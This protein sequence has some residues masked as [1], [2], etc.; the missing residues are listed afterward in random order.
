MLLHKMF[1]I[2]RMLERNLIYTSCHFK[3]IIYNKSKDSNIVTIIIIIIIIKLIKYFLALFI[4]QHYF[5]SIFGLRN[6]YWDV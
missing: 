5:M 1:M 4:I 2:I 3:I 6:S